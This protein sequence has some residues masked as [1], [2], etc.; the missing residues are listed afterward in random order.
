MG[1]PLRGIWNV[2]PFNRHGRLSER[3]SPGTATPTASIGGNPNP[4]TRAAKRGRPYGIYRGQ[5]ETCNEGRRGR[6]PVRRNLGGFVLSGPVCYPTFASPLPPSYEEGAPRR[7]RVRFSGTVATT[8]PVGAAALGGPHA[9]SFVYRKHPLRS[10]G[11][12][13]PPLRRHPFFRKR[14]QGN[15]VAALCAAFKKIAPQRGAKPFCPLSGK[16]GQGDSSPRPS[17]P[18]PAAREN[19]RMRRSRN[20]FKSP[21]L[22]GGGQGGSERGTTERSQ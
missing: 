7:G 6:R 17:S 8:Y 11:S 1:P 12:N 16:G 4:A 22:V 21:L 19:Q 2:I 20:H 3:G 5:S 14:G 10:T 9:V 13:T 18:V 15:K